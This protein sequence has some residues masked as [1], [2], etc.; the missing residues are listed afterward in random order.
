MNRYALFII[1]LAIVLIDYFAI[2]YIPRSSSTIQGGIFA[3]TKD[4]ML[5]ECKFLGSIA[6]GDSKKSKLQN[7]THKNNISYL[8]AKAIKI[9]ANVVVYD[10][11][12]NND[13]S[14]TMGLA[15]SCPDTIKS[16]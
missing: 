14:D 1:M 10:Q 5:T 15:Y 8:T 6:P 2:R 12:Q 16:N 9:K 3:L 7:S 13:K 11:H 4:S